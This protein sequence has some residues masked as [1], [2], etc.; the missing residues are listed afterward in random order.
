[1]SCCNHAI[2]LAFV[3][4]QNGFGVMIAGFDVELVSWAGSEPLVV[5]S[6]LV[7]APPCQPRLNLPDE[8]EGFNVEV[9]QDSINPH[10][11]DWRSTLGA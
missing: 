2:G 7:G 8:V 9:G 10:C 11:P 6:Y 1:M 3:Q 5:S 4:S